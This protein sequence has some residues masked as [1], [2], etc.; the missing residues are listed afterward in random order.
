MEGT[1]YSIT[2]EGKLCLNNIFDYDSWEYFEGELEGNER[3]LKAISNL[4]K[5]EISIDLF[6]Q[7]YE[8]IKSENEISLN[9][10]TTEG[11]ELAGLTKRDIKTLE[12]KKNI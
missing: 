1:G 5:G 9:L 12:F 6:L 4:I 2:D 3:I 7:S 8:Y 11:L 10:Y